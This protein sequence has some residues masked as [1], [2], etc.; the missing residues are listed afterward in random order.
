MIGAKLM[1]DHTHYIKKHQ[2]AVSSLESSLH[3]QSKNPKIISVT[4]FIGLRCNYDCS[5]CPSYNHDNY[6]PHIDKS[7]A[8]HFLDQIEQY[9][10]TQGKKFKLAITGGEPFVHPNFLELLKY[11]KTKNKITQLCVVTNGSLPLSIYEQSSEYITNM[12][13]SLHLEQSDK[14]IDETVEKI[15]KL[16]KIK[17]WF[18]VV[19]L[20]A[21]TGKFEKLRSIIK[22]FHDNHVKF[23]LRKID[24]PNQH[25][26]K[27]IR[28]KDLPNDFDYHKEQKSFSMNK[29]LK[30]T[31]ENKLL[32][33]EQYYST[34]EQKFLN[35]FEAENKWQNIKI[36]LTDKQIELNTD[37]LKTK[38][39]NSWKGWNC[40]I[41][42][43]S[44]W[45]QHTGEVFRGCCMQGPLIGKI[46]Q[47]LN[48]PTE[49]IVCPLQW[50]TVNTDMVIRKSKGKQFDH[51]IND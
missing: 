48:F 47:K 37:D 28:K 2:V 40:Y 23:V 26:Q 16:N 24:S 43:D 3:A 29:I 41:G 46:G 1:H 51:L 44:I 32:N 4:W 9:S 27:S 7:K 39:L 45:I 33:W 34:E 21:M 38:K 12:T 17:S 49:P 36:H 42:I 10:I 19:N 22:N 31:N 8:F 11:S 20:M 30:K 18:F 15:N 25:K 14:V 5:Y 35:A 50:C 13:I 6:S